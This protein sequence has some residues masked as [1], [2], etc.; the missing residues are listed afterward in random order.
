MLLN[1]SG[2]LDQRG[3]T[4]GSPASPLLR[5][6]AFTNRGS[7]PAGQSPAPPADAIDLVDVY[8]RSTECS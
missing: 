7:A 4:H 2:C 6:G 5:A 1:A 8:I 3:G